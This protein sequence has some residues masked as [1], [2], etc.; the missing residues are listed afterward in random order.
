MA[1]QR[2]RRQFE[3]HVRRLQRTVD[4]IGDTEAREIL[5]Q[6]REAKEILR[7]RIAVAMARTDASTYTP[8]QAARLRE[9]IDR[10][11][12]PIWSRFGGALAEADRELVLAAGMG[13]QEGINLTS[14]RPLA[15]SALSPDLVVTSA[16]F[17]AALVGRSEGIDAA[18][19]EQVRRISAT[20]SRGILSGQ[21]PD[22]VARELRV[23]GWLGPLRRADGTMLGVG[24]RAITIA[25]TETNRI[26]N[27]AG[28]IADAR[29]AKLAP[30]LRL[31]KLWVTA[32]DDRVR[33][34]HVEAGQRYRIGGD[35]GPIPL[36]EDFEVGGHP[37][38]GPQDPRLPPE[39]AINC[40]CRRVVVSQE[41]VEEEKAAA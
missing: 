24:A 41:F 37:A 39:E 5:R 40:R 10:V 21:G 3:A 6:L 31:V 29:F 20:V 18:H 22:E 7:D 27:I 16:R 13:S 34:T 19:E 38:A 4:R 17:Q 12:G 32:D 35:P 15:G 36:D 25:R 28:E 8:A 11:L 2:Q 23:G 14:D 9:E 1:T 33:E 26:F 30:R